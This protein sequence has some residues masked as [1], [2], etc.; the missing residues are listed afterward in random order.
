[1]T[2]E[3]I[4]AIVVAI[5]G[6]SGLWGFLQWVLETKCRKRNKTLKDMNSKLDNLATKQEITNISNELASIKNALDT[7]RDLTL[8]MAR[9]KLNEMSNKYLKLGYIP[10]EEYVAYNSIGDAYIR[11]GGNSEIKAKFE[12]VMEDL[13]VKPAR[14]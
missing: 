3:M 9:E 10:Y 13:D 4:L 7:D 11:A 6:S 8:S 2:G 5:V 14:E 1:M 12:L